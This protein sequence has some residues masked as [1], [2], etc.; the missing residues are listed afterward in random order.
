VPPGRRPARLRGSLPE[1]AAGPPGECTAADHVRPAG[2]CGGADPGF[3]YEAGGFVVPSGFVGN[4]RDASSRLAVAAARWPTAFAVACAGERP[5]APARVRGREGRLF[6]CPPQ[7]SPHYDS[8][9]LRWRERGTIMVVS[10]S[11]HTDLHR[12]LVLA[13]AAHLALVPPR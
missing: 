5:I 8:T 10:V 9:L 6:D 3:R 7:A 4:F 11:G 13:L 1:A 12:R 2:I